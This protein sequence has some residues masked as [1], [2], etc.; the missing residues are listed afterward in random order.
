MHIKT[1]NTREE[2]ERSRNK[3]TCS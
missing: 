2:E 3:E 1:I